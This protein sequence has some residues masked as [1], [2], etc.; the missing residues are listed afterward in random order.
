MTHSEVRV[1]TEVSRDNSWSFFE[2]NVTTKN[3]EKGIIFEK[4]NAPQGW[5]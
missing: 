2:Q 3:F 1:S 5:D 4:C